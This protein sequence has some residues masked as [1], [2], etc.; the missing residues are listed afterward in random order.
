MPAGAPFICVY[1]CP[2]VFHKPQ[3]RGLL[4][5]NRCENSDCG[6]EQRPGRPMLVL[7]Q[8]VPRDMLGETSSPNQNPAQLPVSTCVQFPITACFRSILY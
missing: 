7:E 4:K 3:I 6:S 1:S 5:V 2:S 8:M